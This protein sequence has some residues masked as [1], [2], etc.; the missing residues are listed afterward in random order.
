MPLHRQRFRSLLLNAA[1]LR[2]WNP[3]IAWHDVAERKRIVAELQPLAGTFEEIKVD[4][5]IELLARRQIAAGNGLQRGKAVSQMFLA[6]RNVGGRVVGPAIILAGIAD[7]RGVFWILLHPALP[8]GVKEGA[9]VLR[10]LRLVRAGMRSTGCLCSGRLQAA[11]L[12]TSCRR[13]AGVRLL[14]VFRLAKS[15]QRQRQQRTANARGKR[16][17]H[18]HYYDFLEAAVASSLSRSRASITIS[19]AVSAA[20][21]AVLSTSTASPARTSGETLRS[22]S[23]LSRS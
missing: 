12:K 23:R 10:C 4:I 13:R 16:D 2:D 22:R 11:V 3:Q 6:A 18:T 20:S 15:E 9:K 21:I 1:H 8:V 7:I 14:S 5:E 19:R 17:E